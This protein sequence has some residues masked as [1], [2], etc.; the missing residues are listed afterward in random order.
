M[1]LVRVC[2]LGGRL[3]HVSER[4]YCYLLYSW[5]QV[6]LQLCFKSDG[7]ARP[8]KQTIK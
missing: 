6:F 4:Q 1:R 8:Q 5:L 2:L 3:R 7:S